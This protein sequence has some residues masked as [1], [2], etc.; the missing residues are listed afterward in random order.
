MAGTNQF[1]P[2][3]TGSGANALT[4]AQYQALAARQGGFV[5]GIAKSIEVNTSLR[6]ASTI[7]AMI[8][9]FI[10]DL[11]GNDANDDGNIAVL[12]RRFRDALLA[13]LTADAGNSLVHY[14]LDISTTANLLN[15]QTV[16]PAVPSL[17][18][19]MLFEIVPL[20]TVTGSSAIV[21]GTNAAV[22]LFRRNGTPV[23]AGD[24]VAGV[25]FLGIYFGGAIR[26]LG[27]AASEIGTITTTVISNL[28]I[29]G[30]TLEPYA[31]PGTF[32]L[33]LPAG[34]PFSVEE[35]RGAGGGG[36]G[37]DST[38]AAGSGGAGGARLVGI[39]LAITDVTLAITVGSGGLGG[40]G[41]TTPGSGTAGGTTFIVVSSGTVQRKNGLTVTTGQTLCASTGGGGGA[42]GSAA[43]PQPNTAGAGGTSSGGDVNDSG[44]GGGFPIIVGTNN[45]LGGLG[46]PSPG[47]GGSPSANAVAQGNS[48]SSPG[49]GG[50][51]SSANAPGGFGAPGRVLIRH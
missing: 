38:G 48:S 14:G 33:T 26:M 36:G 40:V 41:G 51:G 42:P 23:V 16:V 32:S 35:C 46:G 5:A 18:E 50:N 8:G 21:L 45:R 37:A 11:S 7:A 44:D 3:A 28:R 43:S 24:I 19:G 27:L 2:F 17:A 22:S 1:L 47:S 31:T 6:Q 12:E 13:S 49:V 30:G 10:A 9:Q 20:R 4:V 15:V 39:Y 25:P 29:V 34:T